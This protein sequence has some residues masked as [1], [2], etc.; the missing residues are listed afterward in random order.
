[1]NR[2]QRRAEQPQRSSMMQAEVADALRHHQ[3]GRLD[4]AAAC[5]RR[6]IDARPDIPDL[7][8]NL[9]HVLTQQGR[10]DEAVACIRRAI[11]LRPEFA[12]AHY[13]LG[14]ALAEQGRL[15]EAVACYHRVIDLQPHIPEA[16]NSL[17][18]TLEKL[19]R[20]DAAVAC[21]RTAIALRA[22]YPEAHN[23]L[24]HALGQQGQLDASIAC[25]RS[26]IDLRQSYPEAHNNLGYALQEQRRLD[27]AGACYR[28]AIGLEPDFAEAHFNLALALLAQGD[29]A[30]GWREYEWRWKLPEGIKQRQTFSRP[31]WR[32]EPATGRTLLIHAEQGF[33]DTLQFCRYG[34]LAASCGLRVI[35]QVPQPLVRVL[36]GLPGVLVV[37]TGEPLPAFDLHCPMLSM[38]LAMGTTIETIPAIA[39]YLHADKVQVAAWRTR[40]GAAGADRR[41]RIGL[42]WAGASRTG[43]ALAAIDRRRSVSPVLLAPLLELRALDFFSL[44]KGGVAAPAHFGLTDFMGEMGDFADTA[45]LI[46][47][48]DLV[49]SVDT[50]VAHLAA[51]MGKPVWLLDRFDACWRW[52]DGRRDS[53]WYPTLRVYRQPRAGDWES[54]LAELAQDLRDFAIP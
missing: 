52:L 38:P 22:D 5:Y 12:Q 19:G 4:Q 30:A 16:H 50:A 23:N 53:P 6:A 41:P 13:N 17:G 14:I 28:A 21:F 20:L 47:N 11:A 27:A 32:G 15:N 45:A 42:V 37:A 3:A 51:A 18:Y 9:G 39:S 46:A 8:N 44:Q 24:G 49:I 1:M 43:T 31:Q 2:K 40:L 34:E 54:V 25:Y 7:A 26:A 35:M 10:L 36:R 33:G 29:S 48:L